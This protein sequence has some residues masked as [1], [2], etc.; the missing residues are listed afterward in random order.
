MHKL[1]VRARGAIMVPHHEA[2]GHTCA[3]VGRRWDASVNGWPS[4]GHVVEVP[5]L[6]PTSPHF[7]EYHREYMRELAQGTLWPADEATAQ[8]AGVP[9]DPSFGNEVTTDA[10]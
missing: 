3:F 6:S 9:F 2:Q 10:A 1:K 5:T 4:T 7:P 8:A